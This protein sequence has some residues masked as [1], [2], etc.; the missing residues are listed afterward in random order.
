MQIT[1]YKKKAAE[2]K[3][4]QIA[5]END[6]TGTTTTNTETEA[7]TSPEPM[8]ATAPEEPK[9]QDTKKK[10]TLCISTTAENERRIREYAKAHGATV[11]GLINLW[12]QE[13]T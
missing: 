9:Q 11:S 5:K 13:N 10:H 2:R 1:D 12:I 7:T 8:T 3:A 4:K 6:V